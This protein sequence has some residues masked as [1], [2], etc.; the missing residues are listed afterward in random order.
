MFLRDVNCVDFRE[1]VYSKLFLNVNIQE[2]INEKRKR[3][4]NKKSGC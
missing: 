2:R 4:K 1:I 3:I